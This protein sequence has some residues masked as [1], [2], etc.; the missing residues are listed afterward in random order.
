MI[1][2]RRTCSPFEAQYTD[3]YA[4]TYAPPAAAP[5]TAEEIVVGEAVSKKD[6]DEDGDG[7]VGH[8]RANGLAT[9]MIS[10]SWQSSI[11]KHVRSAGIW[12]LQIM[13]LVEAELCSFLF[14]EP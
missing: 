4:G 13:K 11:S 10:K 6:A 12:Y 14:T 8:R 1:R 5:A 2:T 9:L 7:A 3:I